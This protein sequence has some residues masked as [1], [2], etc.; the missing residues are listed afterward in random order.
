[1]HFNLNIILLASIFQAATNQYIISFKK[2]FRSDFNDHVDSVTSLFSTTRSGESNNTIIHKFD[3][4][5]VGMAA[6]LD[7]ETLEKVKN[8]P[9]VE[10]VEVDGIA[11][12][13]A[14]QRNAP[15]GLARISHRGRLN[16][17]NQGEYLHDTNAGQGIN[18]YVLDSGIN[19]HH[20]DFGGRAKWGAN[21]IPGS[22]NIDGHGHGTHCAGTVGS[23]TYG[24]AKKANLIAVKVLGHNG[25]GHWS[26]IIAG[27]NW[28]VQNSKG[29]NAVISVSI[30]GDRN[31]AVN[32]AVADAVNNGIF[33]VSA[34][35]NENRDAC[36]V[37]PASSPHSFTVGATDIYDRKASFS[38]WG[39]CVNILAPGV[40]VL[41][42]AIGHNSNTQYM[43]GTSMACPHVAGLAAQLLS[44]GVPFHNLKS[45]LLN[46]GTK[47]AIGNFWQT[48]N[49]LGFNGQN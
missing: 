49:I 36:L 38:N 42:T 26:S 31:W 30:G 44:Q 12:A 37:S 27:F 14:V 35:G 47:N 20:R 16:S 7:D 10:K 43:S 5:L 17:K 21:F 32:Q 15:W 9:N 28:A 45:T 22:P 2:E 1:M 46:M 39:R 48:Q 33:V 34:A 18:V 13:F 3:Q 24:V 23:N 11:K 4:V 41:S 6:K 29:R 19:I 40:D 25:Q 8:L